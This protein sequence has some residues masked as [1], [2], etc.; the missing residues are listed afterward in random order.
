MR[1]GDGPTCFFAQL[2][3]IDLDFGKLQTLALDL[4]RILTLQCPWGVA[5]VP[6]PLPNEL[7]DEEVL[8]VEP[9]LRPWLRTLLVL[10]AVA[11]ITVFSV[12][13]WLN[14]YGANG[15]AQ[16]AET[17]MQLGLPECTFK[18]LTGKPCPS[19]GMTTSFAL[20][21]RGD[22]WNSLQANC[23][24]TLLASFCLVMIPYT[25]VSAWRGRFL[26]LMSLDW[27]LPRF[28]VVFAVL[29]LVRWGL[30]LWLG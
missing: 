30:V 22:V 1:T 11:L 2:T 27:L 10:I 12:A 13:I 3:T 17:H 25:L 6:P 7:M 14:P 8:W 18:T 28:I 16:R 29:M 24:G 26:L 15:E 19:C 23:I 9:G 20:F 21:V 5:I 4:R